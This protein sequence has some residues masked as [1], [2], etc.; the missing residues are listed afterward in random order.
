MN[1][2]HA[3]HWSLL[4]HE[5]IPTKGSNRVCT[6]LVWSQIIHICWFTQSKICKFYQGQ[7]AV[8]SSYSP[9]TV[10]RALKLL[11]EKGL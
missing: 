2:N 3:V 4:D 6:W 11:Q 1:I 7:F 9:N 5:V 10:K 8:A